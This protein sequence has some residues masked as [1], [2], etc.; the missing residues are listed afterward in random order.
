VFAGSH[1]I[2]DPDN[3][4]KVFYLANQGDFICVCN[5]DSAMLDLPVESARNPDDRLFEAHTER[6]PAIG[7]RVEVVFEPVAKKK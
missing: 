1:L 7:T 6:I 2:A 5:Q 4:Q 3:P